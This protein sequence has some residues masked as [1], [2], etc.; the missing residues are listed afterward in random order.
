MTR[1]MNFLRSDL[2]FSLI[3]GFALG[4]AGL[5]LVKPASADIPAEQT[6]SIS[7]E[8]PDHIK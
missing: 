2:F 7:V 8:L 1:I 3:G 5:A 6:R 4:V